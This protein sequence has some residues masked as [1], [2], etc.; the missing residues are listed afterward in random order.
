MGYKIKSQEER[1]KT[2]E[3]TMRILNELEKEKT[4]ISK[5][6]TLEA[7]PIGNSCHIIL[8]KKYNGQKVKVILEEEI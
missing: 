6:L 3:K 4:T 5:V 8:P 1:N 2:W 7:K